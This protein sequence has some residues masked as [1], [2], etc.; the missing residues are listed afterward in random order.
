MPNISAQYTLGPCN[1]KIC[2]YERNLSC[3]WTDLVDSKDWAT[4]GLMSQENGSGVE[5]SLHTFWKIL[6]TEASLFDW[7]GGVLGTLSV[8]SI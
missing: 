4:P 1:T 6:K 7:G 5:S 2:H 3:L 8:Q